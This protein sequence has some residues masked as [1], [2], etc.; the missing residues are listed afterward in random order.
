MHLIQFILTWSQLF[1]TFSCLLNK[2]SS[3]QNSVYLLAGQCTD[4]ESIANWLFCTI[5]WPV[6]KKMYI[7][8]TAND[9]SHTLLYWMSTP[10]S[11]LYCSYSFHMTCHRHWFSALLHLSLFRQAN[12][13]TSSAI[14][15]EHQFNWTWASIWISVA[16]F[17]PL[18][19]IKNH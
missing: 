3:K 15:T 4:S 19:L 14:C 5:S 7:S 10:I 8:I 18:W 13:F 2:R 12:L 11:W 6:L 16:S 1:P 9:I 17:F